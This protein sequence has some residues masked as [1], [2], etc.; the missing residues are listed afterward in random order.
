MRKSERLVWLSVTEKKWCEDEQ[1][2]YAKKSDRCDSQSQIWNGVETS[3]M[4][5]LTAVTISQ[6][7]QM[8]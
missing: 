3:E 1:D 7:I 6:M 8:I 2:M 5:G 4:N